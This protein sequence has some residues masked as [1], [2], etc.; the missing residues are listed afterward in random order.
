MADPSQIPMEDQI[1]EQVAYWVHQ[2]TQNAELTIDRDGQPVEVSVSLTG[3][4]AHVAF[5]SDQSQTRD[6]LDTSVAQLRELLRGE[7]LELAGVSI[8]QSGA[9]AG[10]DASGRPSGRGEGGARIGRVQAAGGGAQG[11]GDIP[12]PASRPD[13]AL[14][15]FA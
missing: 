1:A 13:R 4:E 3:N 11:A 14:D 9:G 5:R 10:G 15:V 6:M 8:G 12:R 2:K 7:G